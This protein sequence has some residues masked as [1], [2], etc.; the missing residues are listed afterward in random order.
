[1]CAEVHTSGFCL[2]LKELSA[3]ESQSFVHEI[4]FQSL[5]I[6][7]IFNFIRVC[8]SFG[9]KAD[10]YHKESVFNLALSFPHSSTI[11]STAVRLIS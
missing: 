3:G 11:H 4:F 5:Q 8:F 1:M 6:V 2:K 10:G 9:H 7:L